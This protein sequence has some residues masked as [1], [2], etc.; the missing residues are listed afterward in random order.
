[1]SRSRRILY[2]LGLVLGW[3]ALVVCGGLVLVER[4]G[5]L[6]RLAR[7]TLARELPGER[8]ELERAGL[9]WFEPALALHGLKLGAEA[10]PDVE[11]ERLRL[12]FS[13]LSGHAFGLARVELRNGRVRLS[14]DLHDRVRALLDRGP[15]EPRE[16]ARP[17]SL[18]L[19]DL[20]L[21]LETPEWGEWEL[22]ELDLRFSSTTTDPAVLSGRLRPSAWWGGNTTHP[23]LVR[24]YEVEPGILELETLARGLELDLANAPSGLP[25]EQVAPWSPS[26]ELSLQATGRLSLSR[27]DTPSG[28]MKLQLSDG[29]VHPPGIEEPFRSV[30]LALVA[31]LQP[32]GE[33]TLFDPTAWN[34]AAELS[35]RWREMPLAVHARV[36]DRAREGHLAEAWLRAP[37][38]SV[39]EAMIP[40]ALELL[41][42]VIPNTSRFIVHSLGARGAADLT[43]ALA[44]QDSWRLGETLRGRMHQL[45]HVRAD[46]AAAITY[47]GHAS[48]DGVRRSGFPVPVTELSG[49]LVFHFDPDRVRPGLLGIVEARGSHGNGPLRGAGLIG[50]PPPGA[51]ETGK[52]IDLDLHIFADGL[53]VDEQLEQGARG[54]RGVVPE[55]QLWGA[56]GPE[57]G[58]LD[59]DLRLLMSPGRDYLASRVHIDLEEPT[60]RWKEFPVPVT[61]ARGTVE[62]VSDGRG[63]A[64]TRIRTTGELRTAETFDFAAHLVRTD[65]RE[66]QVAEVTVR[67]LSLRGDDVKIVAAFQPQVA[68]ALEGYGPKGFADARIQWTQVTSDRAANL[69]VELSPNGPCEVDPKVFPMTTRDLRGRVVVRAERDGLAGEEGDGA[70]DWSAEA[71]AMPL[72]GTWG[73]GIEVG[74]SA[75]FGGDDGARVSLFGAGIEAKNKRLLGSL[76][77][78]I[79]SREAGGD[80]LDLTAL[81]I[82][83]RLDFDAELSLSETDDGLRVDPR[84][85]F[86]LFLRENDITSEKGFQLDRLDGRATFDVE[87]G[88]LDAER[89]SAVLGK[90]PVTLLD[91]SFERDEGT[92]RLE[93]RLTGESLPLDRE[94]LSLFLDQDTLDALIEELEWRGRIDV[95]DAWLTFDSR[96]DGTTR[97]VLSGPAT[98]S[99]VYFEAGLPAS[100]RS[101]Q[102]QVDR[103]V[104]EGGSVRGWGR[105]ADLYGTIAG[106]SLESA[107]MLVTYVEPRVS[108][109]DLRGSLIDSEGKVFPLGSAPDGS[110]SEE[111]VPGGSAFA[112]DLEAP[113]PFEAGF[114]I[115]NVDVAGLTQGLFSADIANTGR[116]RGEIRLTGNLEELLEIRGSGYLALSKGQLWSVP[117]VRDLFTQLGLDDTAVFDSMSMQFDVSDGVIHMNQ[118]EARSPILKLVGEGTLDFDGSLRHDLEVNYSLI[119]K[120]G[121]LRRLFYSIQKS[122]LRIAIRGDMERPQV[123]LKSLFS[124]LTGE[125]DSKALPLPDISEL[126]RRF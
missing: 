5:L 26:T 6:T 67:K 44:L 24:G 71:R 33:E 83:G 22:G 68:E 123:I 32:E 107:E 43:V 62:H 66:D 51:R 39:G 81:T 108:F 70:R 25:L 13:P 42:H 9:D 97:L 7:E 38:L 35:A 96:Q 93:T 73:T 125:P 12:C 60:F 2:K 57:G 30:A 77:S 10:A 72:F 78:A 21:A 29:F 1:M 36:G 37:E 64:A 65:E 111:Q 118:L 58:A 101:A 59:L 28:R 31:E 47:H 19:D 74:L 79:S 100:I 3:T 48:E 109:E 88:R 116:V 89:L 82:D 80:R 45:V 115:Q 41:R 85:G 17:P 90:T 124:D 117:V 15:R 120:L 87:A 54:L 63:N 14:R 86:H 110:A 113:F 105:L 11:I 126:P 53:A 23:V 50:T 76:S 27:L 56:Y 106:R 104:F 122:L 55:D 34:G 40:D 52:E 69:L 121:F 61:R 102:V 18:V 91:T 94:H 16:A 112:M 20:R 103:L 119:D 92:L 49:D 4:T 98:L 99:D 84:S 75:A 95:H 46:G 8:V 114:A